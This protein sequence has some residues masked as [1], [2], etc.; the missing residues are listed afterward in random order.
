MLDDYESVR[1]P[2]RKPYIS[3]RNKGQD[4]RKNELIPKGGTNEK[5]EG[6][7]D[8][9]Q[10]R[11]PRKNVDREREFNRQRPIRCFACGKTG[12]F[13]INCP[14]RR[15]GGT[16]L[17]NRLIIEK[18]A[19]EILAPHMS[20]AIVN[21]FEL[22]I[23][24]DTGS[25]FDIISSAYVPPHFLTE[26]KVWLKSALDSAAKCLPVAKVEIAGSFG[27]VTTKAAVTTNDPKSDLY[28]LSNR[29]AELI[30]ELEST[31]PATEQINAITRLQAARGEERR[32]PSS[33]AIISIPEEMK[34]P[35]HVLGEILWRWKIAC[36][37]LVLIP[38]KKNN[39]HAKP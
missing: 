26:E 30:A 1:K 21:G 28:I 23:L 8:R 6:S 36:L 3:D 16:E 17:V 33:S 13:K 14:D 35:E 4:R 29:T 2:L 15:K 18:E 25:S 22:D 10:F 32:D 11:S 37:G 7:E 20:K 9:N 39:Q 24:R 34:E 38:Y 19:E 31:R 5:T 27:T 12:H